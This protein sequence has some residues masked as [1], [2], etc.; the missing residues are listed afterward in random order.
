MFPPKI[1]GE[2]LP[3]LF[4]LLVAPSIL[5]A[6][7]CIIPIFASV[8]TWISSLLVSFPFLSLIRT[9]IGFRAH[10]DNPGMISSQE[11]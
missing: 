1:L 8:F 7:G 2:T 5:E 3:F 10:L 11:P 6:H 4:Q 9:L